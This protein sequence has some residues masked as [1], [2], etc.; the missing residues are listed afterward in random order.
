MSTKTIFVRDYTTNRILREATAADVQAATDP[1][2]PDYIGYLNPTSP[3]NGG[4]SD[5]IARGP[6]GEVVAHAMIRA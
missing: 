1:A 6:H 2:H 5:F 3:R 4:Y